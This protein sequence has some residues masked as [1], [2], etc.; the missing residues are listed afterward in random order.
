MSV[1]GLE[2]DA[3]EQILKAQGFC[4]TI[5][6]YVSKR[7]IEHADSARVI[8]Q[9]GIGNNSMEITVSHFKTRMLDN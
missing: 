7:G 1:L 2:A 5:I 3:A 4:V 9:R 6:E 8:R